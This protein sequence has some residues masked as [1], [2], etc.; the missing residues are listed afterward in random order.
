M[1]PEKQSIAGELKKHLADSEFCILTDY[2]GLTVEKTQEL[3]D[4]LHETSAHMQV[5]RNRLL[6]YVAK[7]QGLDGLESALSGPTAMVFGTGNVVGTA[8]VLQKFA[9]EHDLP[10]V[11]LGALDGEIITAKQID[12]LANLPSREELLGK[13]VG[14]IAAPLSQVVGVLNQKVLSLVYVLNAVKTKKETQ[15]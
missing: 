11:K 3:R 13:V 12:Q 5:V 10:V 14:T 7:E 6:N 8:K 2:Q 9:K 15:G 4:K 1:R